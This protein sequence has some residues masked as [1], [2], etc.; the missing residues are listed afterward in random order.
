MLR[1]TPPIGAV[2]LN[3][4]RSDTSKL[5]V[6]VVQAGIIT[7]IQETLRSLAALALVT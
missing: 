3:Q 4:E 6:V 5:I 7:A 1:K 2:H